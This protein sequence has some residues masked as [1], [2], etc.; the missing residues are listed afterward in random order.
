MSP[1]EGNPFTGLSRK[2]LG[3]QAVILLEKMRKVQ[4]PDGREAQFVNQ[5]ADK[6]VEAF[7]SKVNQ[8]GN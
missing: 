6:L 3:Q 5:Q 1:F 7:K 4:R 8:E 2:E